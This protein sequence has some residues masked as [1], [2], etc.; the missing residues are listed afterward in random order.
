MVD[1]SLRKARN[2][3]NKLSS[4]GRTKQQDPPKQLKSNAYEDF[5]AVPRDSL[6][7]PEIGV[8]DR[9]KVGTSMQR[10]LSVHNA[11][12]VPP[13]IDF[14]NAPALPTGEF[15]L[16]DNSLL[17]PELIK[18]NQKRMPLDIYE[19]RSLRD[20]LSDPKFLAKRFVHEKLGDATALEVDQFSSNLN[21][22]SL[23]IEE[24]IKTNINKSYN[25]IMIVNM[26]LGVACTEL[27]ELRS[28]VKQLQVVMDQFTSMAEKRLQLEKEQFRNSASSILTT[29][30][31]ST[32]SSLLPP[33]KS[34][35]N[36]KDRT[37]VY[38]LEKMWTT[39]LSSLFKSVEGAQKYISRDSGR[40]IL[41]E[42]SHWVE[43]NIATLK[44]MHNVHIFILNDMILVAANRQEKNNELVA[45]QCCF[46]RDLSVNEEQN[47]TLSFQFGNKNHFLYRSRTAAEYEK[48][49]SELKAAKDELRDIYEAEEDNA[50][51]LRNSFTYLQS[52]QQSPVRDV[53]SP[54]KGHSRQRSLGTVHT[55]PDRSQMHQESLLQNISLSMHARSRSGDVN[56]ATIKL[57]LADE[58]LEELNVPVTRMNF[59]YAIRKLRSIESILNGIVAGTEEEVMLLDLLK[60]KCNQNRNTITQKLTHVINTEH[61]DAE[62]LEKSAKSLI[63]LGMPVDALQLFLNNRSNLIQDLVLQVGV[64]DNSNS[65]ITQVAVIRFQTIKKVAIQFQRLFEGETAKYSSVLVSWCNDEVDK[66]FNL[67]KKQL[68]NDDQLTPQAI[69]ISRKQI[70]ELKTV[71]MDFVY[72]LDD[73]LKVH[74]NKI[75][76]K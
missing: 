1:F 67:M 29:K 24:E 48:L 6:K 69:K 22:L 36:N 76:Y 54:A 3:W 35:N 2:N 50:R 25:E 60:M 21:D 31:S 5:A 34:T 47:Y 68:I 74:S 45:D 66:H 7:L 52:T 44:P 58:E 32:T 13:T 56:Q 46:L 64:H 9:R 39:E 51:K 55:T 41:M 28:K 73:F 4:P 27:D 75:H 72:K 16:R 49:L 61:L 65:Y 37:S 18:P 33:V 14:S 43:I 15:P 26:E 23:E 62:K 57:K 70:D 8:K 59:E 20:I 10:R 40:H 53:S 63:S 19:G 17:P 12:Y 30:S 42:S 11:K 38:M 71:G